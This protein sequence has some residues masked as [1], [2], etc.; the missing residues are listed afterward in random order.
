MHS[1]FLD[2]AQTVERRSG[3]ARCVARCVARHPAASLLLSAAC[4]IV[5]GRLVAPPTALLLSDNVDV[6]ALHEAHGHAG[7]G[8]QTQCASPPHKLAVELVTPVQYQQQRGACW[9]F[10][11]ADLLE[12]SYRTRGVDRGYLRREQ[13]LRLSEQALGAVLTTA[14]KDNKICLAGDGD[15]AYTGNSTEGGET[16]WIY[17]LQSTVGKTAALPHSVCAYVPTPTAD[18]ECPGMEKAQAVSPLSFHVSS[19]RTYYTVDDIKDALWRT[20]RV[21]SLSLALFSQPIALPCT[22]ATK[23]LYGCDPQDKSRCVP[24]PI[25]PAFAGVD[26]CIA[27]AR[28]R[29]HLGGISAMTP[30]RVCVHGV[31]SQARFGANMRGE[32][33]G[34]HPSADRNVRAGGHALGLV[35]YNDEYTSSAGHVGG[36]ILKNSWCA[37]PQIP[38]D[39]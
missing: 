39:D 4:G 16:E 1:G 31:Y 22:H 12:H 20:R 29:R 33:V 23:S 7:D 30:Q 21:L 25:E 36:F 37:H 34:V 27:Q 11:L 2:E 24:C 13:Y 10:A 17:K 6:A 8:E 14:C 18:A 9:L 5:L 26:C 19:M 15:T 28:S 35:G 32:F 3:P 38:H